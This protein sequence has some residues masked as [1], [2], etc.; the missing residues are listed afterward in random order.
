M[1]GD[2]P[3]P[4]PPRRILHA[5]DSPGP[6][7][8]RAARRA[9]T[10]GGTVTDRVR[11]RPGESLALSPAG[12]ARAQSAADGRRR[13]RPRVLAAAGGLR[14]PGLPGYGGADGYRRGA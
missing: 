13:A 4:P 12:A 11:H 3:P 1:G 10:N 5:N 2:D 6:V 9:A 7:G 14:D 8:H